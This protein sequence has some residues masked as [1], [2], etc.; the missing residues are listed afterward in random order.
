M[1]DGSK[2]SGAVCNA[3]DVDAPVIADARGIG[4][5]ASE[6]GR[7]SAAKGKF[8]VRIGGVA[9]GLVLEVDTEDLG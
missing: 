7:I 4:D 1:G 6:L 5:R 3:S 9:A 2:A 8:A